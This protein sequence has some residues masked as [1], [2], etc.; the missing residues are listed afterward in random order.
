MEM[1]LKHCHTP[2]PPLLCVRCINYGDEGFQAEGCWVFGITVSR[3][4]CKQ[5]HCCSE[6]RNVPNRAALFLWC[7]PGTL[8]SC[9]CSVSAAHEIYRCLVGITEDTKSACWGLVKKKNKKNEQQPTTKNKSQQKRAI[10]L[11]KTKPQIPS[12][13]RRLGMESASFSVNKPSKPHFIQTSG[14]WWVAPSSKYWQISKDAENSQSVA[15]Y[16]ALSASPAERDGYPLV[17]VL[18][19]LSVL[20]TCL[21]WNQV[22]RL[23][24]GFYFLGTHV[25]GMVSKLQLPG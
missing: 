13:C 6:W 5:P 23:K 4:E 10:L 3:G 24:P 22:S 9:S 12:W 15:C 20:S 7:A 21:D 8:Y 25:S 19:L 14:V 16:E 17:G 2:P 1:W 18:C 11:V